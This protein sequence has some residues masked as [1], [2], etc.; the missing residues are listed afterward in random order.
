MQVHVE[1]LMP[2]G[3]GHQGNNWRR[4]WE[5]NRK[6][7]LQAERVWLQRLSSSP[8]SPRI[9]L[10]LYFTS[11]SSKVDAMSTN[12]MIQS[13]KYQFLHC[14]QDME[15]KQEEQARYMKELQGH[16]EHLQWENDQL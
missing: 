14:N 6:S 13:L 8:P 10:V 9:L 4:L 7:R 5:P 16:V 15:R 1:L 11:D 2:K 3:L 12:P